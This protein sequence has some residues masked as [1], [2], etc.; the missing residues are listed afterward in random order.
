MLDWQQAVNDLWDS[1][2]DMLN[3]DQIEQLERLH[4]QDL[5]KLGIL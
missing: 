4:E 2:T 1:V 3:Q 5:E